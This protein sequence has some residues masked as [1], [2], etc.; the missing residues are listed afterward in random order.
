[1]HDLCVIRECANFDCGISEVSLL[2]CS[3]LI[4]CCVVT[5]LL[6]GSIIVCGFF[7]L[8]VVNSFC[9]IDCTGSTEVRC[10]VGDGVGQKKC[11]ESVCGCSKMGVFALVVKE[12]NSASESGSCSS[13]IC[14]AG[15]IVMASM[16]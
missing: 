7:R 11:K 10:A 5:E 2:D 4:R 16:I 12:S 3:G 9:T 14:V 6:V 8:G 1:M 15:I 13:W